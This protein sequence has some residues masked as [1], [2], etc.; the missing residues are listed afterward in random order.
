MMV[1][2]L[3][4]GEMGKEEGEYALRP[5]RKK[6]NVSFSN[7][8]PPFLLFLSLTTRICR[9][10][11]SDVYRYQG[12]DYE[13]IQGTIS[14]NNFIKHLKNNKILFNVCYVITNQ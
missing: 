13:I 8:P 3:E 5:G 6:A 7:R 9:C 10:I 12:G 1:A 11:K 4:V 2:W 14:L